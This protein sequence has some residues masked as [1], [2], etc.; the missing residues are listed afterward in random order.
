MTNTDIAIIVLLS[1]LIAF[2][3]MNAIRE[4]FTEDKEEFIRY[5][6]DEELDEDYD[7]N[8]DEDLNEDYEVLTK[9]FS[10]FDKRY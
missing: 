5:I 9:L 6:N 10:K 2:N 1:V 8:F 4:F 3:I 7:E